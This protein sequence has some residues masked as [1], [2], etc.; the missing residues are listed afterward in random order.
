MLIVQTTYAELLERCAASSF[1]AAFPEDGN[2]TSK[3]IKGRRY[4]YF[5]A[6]SPQ[7]R[8]QRYV[9]PETAKLLER[10]ERHKERR[11][12]EGERRALVSTLVRS[13]RLPAPLS[14]IG[15]V[16]AALA[17]A[18]IFRLRGVLVGTV[19]YQ[20]YPAMLGM[21][22]PGALLQTSDVDIAQFTNVS[23]AIGD[24]T[25]PILDVLKG[26]DK[27][28]REIPHTAGQEFA[29]S[30]EA[31]GSLRV[32][33]LRPNMGP[34][35]D[36]PARL[37]ALQTAAQPLRFLDYLIHEPEQAVVLHGAGI[38]VHVPAPE[39]YAI[40]KLILSG[41]RPLGAAKSDKDLNQAA[42]LVEPLSDKRPRELKA[43]W[44][45]AFNRGPAWRQLLLDA[46]RRLEPDSRDLLLKTLD[47]PRQILPK[48]DL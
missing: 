11:Q 46:M 13:Y 5:Q 3:T 10:I 36:T 19:A 27:S 7:G 44:D 31:R 43:A 1:G 17:H 20:C 23:I 8:S 2:F 4:W 37:P 30:Y 38:L 24:Q 26:V 34:E 9:G 45:E 16:L 39:R 18:G 40:H 29:T 47:R 6:T 28:F 32:D 41:R 42:S 14:R 25:P 12:D 48:I 15:E 33:F 22:L 21:K 35:T